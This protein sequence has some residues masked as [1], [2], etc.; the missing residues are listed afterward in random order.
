MFNYCLQAFFFGVGGVRAISGSFDT[1]VEGGITVNAL[2]VTMW[3]HT[4]LNPYFHLT[5]CM[6]ADFC[7]LMFSNL[8][9][10]FKILPG[11]PIKFSELMFSNLHILF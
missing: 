1:S 8:I 6:Y 10:Y 7:D 3:N 2:S 11:N 5:R 4:K 9:F